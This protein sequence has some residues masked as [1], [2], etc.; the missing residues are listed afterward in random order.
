M[1]LTVPIHPLK[2]KKNCRKMT[3]DIL[4]RYPRDTKRVHV[5]SMAI[6]ALQ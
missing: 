2:K 3:A 4:V 5:Y 1:I 6:A